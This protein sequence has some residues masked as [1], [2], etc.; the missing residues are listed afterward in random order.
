[1]DTPT[2]YRVYGQRD[3]D[4]A[5]SQGRGTL[6]LLDTCGRLT[7]VEKAV[8]DAMDADLRLPKVLYYR[9]TPK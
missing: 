9:E 3:V 8:L 6:V 7:P 1:M 4:A 2:L 5:I